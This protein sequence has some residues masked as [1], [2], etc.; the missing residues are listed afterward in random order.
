MLKLQTNFI[1]LNLDKIIEKLMHKR[2]TEFL[3]EQKILYCK[4]YGFHK[5]FSTPHAIINLI[6]LMDNLIGF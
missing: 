1:C 4:Q 3:N 5:G 2:L 6:N